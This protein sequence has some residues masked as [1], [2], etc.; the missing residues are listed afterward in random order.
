MAKQIYD[1]VAT[2]ELEAVNAM[3]ASIGEAPLDTLDGAT[4]SDVQTAI[5]ILRDTTREVQSEGWRFNTEFGFEIAPSLAFDYTDSSGVTT[6]LGVY[7]AP[8]SLA[9]FGMTQ[10]PDQQGSRYPDA[11]LRPAR[12]VIM[13]PAERNITRSPDF[14]GTRFGAQFQSTIAQGA[15]VP[16]TVTFDLPVESVTVTCFDPGIDKVNTMTAYNELGAQIGF[17]TFDP[18]GPPGV[19]I[20]STKT[21]AV[22]GIKSLLL[23]PGAG[24]YVAYSMTYIAQGIVAI[25]GPVFYD[26]ARNR[27]G[28]P[29]TERSHLYI[30]AVWLFDFESLPETCRNYIVVQASRRLAYNVL[31]S[32]ELGRFKNADEL[33]ALR[34]LKRDQGED[35]DYSMLDNA[36]VAVVFQD[37]LPMQSGVADPRASPGPQHTVIT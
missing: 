20:P 27:D 1:L 34:R 9:K 26:R 10:S 6:R 31:G 29:L 24:D 30:D 33:R 21:I 16:L 25:D 14:P 32:E 5:N 4:Q 17:A 15:S 28:W 11:V 35:D 36:D 22:A 2:T 37:R 3:L 8:S 12:S 13:G 18:G 23:T 19:N 7:Q